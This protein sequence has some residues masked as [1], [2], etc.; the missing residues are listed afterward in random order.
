MAAAGAF[1]VEGMDVRPLNAF[2]VSS[3]NPDS[4]SVSECSITWIS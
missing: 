1:G 4:L 3:T 2:T